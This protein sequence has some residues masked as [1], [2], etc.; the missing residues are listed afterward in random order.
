MIGTTVRKFETDGWR[1]TEKRNVRTWRVT[2][3]CFVVERL[4]SSPVTPSPVT[5][6]PARASPVSL[7]P[8][9]RQAAMASP[10]SDGWHCGGWRTDG[11]HRENFQNNFEKKNVWKRDDRPEILWWRVTGGTTEILPFPTW[12]KSAYE[13]CIR[14][15][16]RTKK[17]VRTSLC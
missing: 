12:D 13:E 2:L 14:K 15:Q 4:Q 6:S 7:S 9:T 17:K 3:F 10:V 11:W 16:V 5:A 1:V 8:V